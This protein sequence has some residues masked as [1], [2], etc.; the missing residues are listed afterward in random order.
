MTGLAD[1]DAFKLFIQVVRVAGLPTRETTKIN[2]NIN[3]IYY[4]AG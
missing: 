4:F 1:V 3:T 2:F